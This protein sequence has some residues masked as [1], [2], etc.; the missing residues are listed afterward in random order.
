VITWFVA[1]ITD[2]VGRGPESMNYSWLMVSVF[3]YIIGYMGL[4]QPEIFSGEYIQRS[5]TDKTAFE[6][7][8]SGKKYEKST[9]TSEKGEEYYKKLQR[10]MK[11]DKPFLDG[12]L[13]L[14]SLARLLG[15]STH[16]LSQVINE[17]LKQ[18]FFEFVN[19]HRVE[20]AKKMIIDPKYFNFSI[21]TIGFEAGF[22]S[23]SAFNNAFKK[24]ASMTPSQFRANSEAK[25]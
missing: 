9:L 19:S 4:R 16:H 20:E 17:R 24:H 10:I 14:P 6:G 13:T 8:A 18:N 1:L 5:I 12:N 15:I 25:S 2:A 22:N 7:L 23:I 21:A 11:E 3:M